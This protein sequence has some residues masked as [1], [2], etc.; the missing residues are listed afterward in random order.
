M[1]F[2]VALERNLFNSYNSK[3]KTGTYIRTN[4]VLLKIMSYT[5]KNR[6]F[7]CKNIFLFLFHLHNNLSFCMF[8]STYQSKIE[9]PAFPAITSRNISKISKIKSNEWLNTKKR[10][11]MYISQTCFVKWISILF[12]VSFFFH[13]KTLD[14]DNELVFQCVAWEICIFYHWVI[15]WALITRVCVSVVGE[16]F[17]FS[18]FF[19]TLNFIRLCIFINDIRSTKEN[20]INAYVMIWGC[21]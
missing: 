16:Q 9:I 15:R 20:E 21:K 11:K 1:K 13:H 19:E 7:L 14:L 17:S 2:Q 8:I 10:L 12:V 4:D 5:R 18:L 6:L 3:T